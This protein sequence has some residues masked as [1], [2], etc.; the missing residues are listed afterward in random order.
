MRSLGSLSY[1]DAKKQI[2]R[3]GGKKCAFGV[4]LE[5]PRQK[6][7]IMTGRKRRRQKKMS[8]FTGQS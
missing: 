7:G 2:T 6:I 8:E 4:R 3:T 1:R 5:C